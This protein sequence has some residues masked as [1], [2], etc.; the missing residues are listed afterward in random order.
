MF[1]NKKGENVMTSEKKE[2]PEK[3]SGPK[4]IPD[5]V[6]ECLIKEFK[7]D[8]EAPNFLQMVVRPKEIN[9]EHKSFYI[10]IFDPDEAQAKNFTVKDYT[11]LDEAP[12]LIYYEG[13]YEEKTKKSPGYCQLTEKKKAVFNIDL[14][15]EA[16]ILARIEAL[17]DPGSSV[18]FYQAAGPAS[19]GPLGRG[20]AIVELQPSVP[21]KKSRYTIYT[22]NVIGMEPVGKGSKIWESNNTKEIAKWVAQGHRKR[23]C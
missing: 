16:E 18:F 4:E 8:S 20:A 7:V 2:K 6:R 3:L 14:L 5:V 9:N 19:G 1:W 11:S 12:D 23:F 13:Y 21:G 10:R 22:A 15:S 17:R